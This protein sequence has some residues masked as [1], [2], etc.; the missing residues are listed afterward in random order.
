MNSNAGNKNTPLAVTN[1]SLPPHEAAHLVAKASHQERRSDGR[2]ASRCNSLFERRAVAGAHFAQRGS[3]ADT[4]TNWRPGRESFLFFSPHDDDSAISVAVVIQEARRNQIPV[5]IIVVTDGRNGYVSLEDRETII[6]RRREETIHSY[7]LLGVP[8][9]DIVFLNF[10]DGNLQNYY[11]RR[12]G[13]TGEPCDRNGYT[14]LENHFVYQLRR[15]VTSA[16]QQISPTRIFAPSVADYHQDH[17]A[18]AR[19][20]PISIFHALGGIWPECGAALVAAPVLYWHCVYC[21]FPENQVPNIRVT[22]T[23]EAFQLKMRSIEAYNSQGQIASIIGQ[24]RES[25]S[26]EYLYEE[27]FRLFKPGMYDHHFEASLP[28]SNA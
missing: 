11:G 22:A 27:T 21:P 26:V 8:E 12:L 5:R 20:I 16:D 24:L 13:Q 23:P 6:N 17:V 19:E 4:F 14:G 15:C 18:V 2:D 1:E 28:D 3:F 9:S 10:P 25:P 7:T